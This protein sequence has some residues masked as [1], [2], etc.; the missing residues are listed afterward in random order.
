MKKRKC[1]IGEDGYCHIPLAN[2]EGEVITDAE[3][4]N[5]ANKYNWNI[6]KLGYTYCRETVKNKRVRIAI[7]RMVWEYFNG[8]IPLGKEIDHINRI[9]T[10]NRIKNLRVCTR[11]ENLRNISGRG[12]CKFKGVN[13]CKN[14]WQATI[15][16]SKRRISLGVFKTPELA[17]EMYDIFA[18]HYYRDFAFLNFQEEKEFYKKQNIKLLMPARK[19]KSS[20]YYGVAILRK[21]IK[22]RKAIFVARVVKDY[23]TINIGSSTCEETAARM[24]DLYNIEHN[25]GKK[26]NFPE[27]LDKYKNGEIKILSKKDRTSSKFI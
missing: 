1:Y 20:K 18:Y 27:D 24:V 12:Q 6:C 19:Q 4:I 8:K 5:E 2:G 21:G 10:D 26:I 23:K 7:H 16:P 3:Y 17:A 13:K 15:K 22:N 11:A 25:L 14:G 9:K